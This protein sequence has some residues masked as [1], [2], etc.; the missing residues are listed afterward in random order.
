MDL[1]KISRQHGQSACWF[2]YANF[3]VSEPSVLNTLSSLAS[4]EGTQAVV[5][6]TAQDLLSLPC[7]VS[8]LRAG[9]RVGGTIAAITCS[10]LLSSLTAS[11]FASWLHSSPNPGLFYNLTFSLIMFVAFFYK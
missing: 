5:L 2:L 8:L 11:E 10:N 9:C 6:C 1:A 4:D 7:L 3:L